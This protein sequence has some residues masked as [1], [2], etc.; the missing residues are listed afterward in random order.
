M[1]LVTKKASS[2][3]KALK[4]GLVSRIK[5]KKNIFKRRIFSIFKTFAMIVP[6]KIIIA[7]FIVIKIDKSLAGRCPNIK[8]IDSFNFDWVATSK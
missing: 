1:M 4:T 7:A 5:T 2:Q 3:T 6:I 8:S